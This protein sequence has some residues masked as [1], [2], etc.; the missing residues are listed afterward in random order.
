MYWKDVGT[1]VAVLV[2]PMAADAAAGSSRS[3][4]ARAL[5]MRARRAC[6]VMAAGTVPGVGVMAATESLTCA[7]TSSA[8]SAFSIALV[9][10][11]R[12]VS[13]GPYSNLPG[14]TSR[15]SGIEPQ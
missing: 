7:Q 15:E 2:P 6:V 14:E 1:P 4:S 3:T 9:R 12:V 5:T 8:L 13:D 10:I 11:A